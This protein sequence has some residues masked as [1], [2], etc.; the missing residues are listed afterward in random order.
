[1]DMAKWLRDIGFERYEP[2]FAEHAIDADVVAELTEA[3]LEKLQIPLGDRKRLLKAIRGTFAEQGEAKHLE[4]AAVRQPQVAERR[5]LTVMICDLVGSTALSARLDP[6]DTAAVFDAFH[7]T[8]ARIVKAYDGFLSDFRGDGILAYFGHPRAHEDDAERTV[9]AALDIIDGTSRLV[10]RA[11]EPLSVRIGIASG[12]VVVGDLSGGGAL[13]DNA[14]IGDPPN[15][16]SRL[17]ALAEPGKIVIAGATRRLL[18]NAFRLRDLGR[19]DLKGFAEPVAAWSVE[20]IVALESRFKAAHPTGLT[21]LIDREEE[22]TF[23]RQ[24]QRLAWGGEGQIV[25]ISGEEGVGKSR[26]IASLAE[27][28]ADTEHIQLLYQCS[29][30]HSNSV[31]YPFIAQLERAAGFKDDD[32]SEQRLEKLETVLGRG[33][34]RVDEEAPLFATMLSLPFAGRY[35]PLALSPPQQRRR[36]LSAIL[37]YIEGLARKGPLLFAFEDAHW[38]DATS[39]ELLNLLI[40]RVRQLPVLGLFTFRSEFE[41]PWAGFQQVSMMSLGRLERQHIEP[42]VTQVTAGRKLPV[43]VMKQIVAKTDGNPLFIEELTK[44]VLE[45]EI[46]IDDGDGYRASGPLPP[47]AIPATLQDSLMARLDRLGPAKEIA[48]VGSAIGREFSYSLVSALV[49]R[50]DSALRHALEQLEDSE[51]VICRGDPPDAM[52]TFKHALVQEVAYESL[53]KSRRNLLHAEIARALENRFHSLVDSQP[54]ILARHFTEA[55]LVD[56]AIDYWLK[57]G[58]LALSRSANAEAVKHLREGLKLTESQPQSA[59]RFRHEL[60]LYLALGPATAATEGDAA[61]ETLRIFSRARELLGNAGSPTEQMTV[62]WGAYLAQSE[63]A[64]HRRALDVA[65]Q[66]LTLAADNEHPGLSALANRFMG[67]TLSNMGLFAEARTQLERTLAICASHK[68][69]IAAYR[70]FGTDDEVMALSFLAMTLLLLGH[71]DQSD[72]AI[73]QALARA[74]GLRLAFTTSWALS[75]A[76][77]LGVLGWRP[78]NA[79][80]HAEEAIAHSVEHGLV[81]HERRARFFHGA[82]LAQNDDPHRGVALMG[83]SLSVTKSTARNRRTLF[84]GQLAS[85]H[86]RL[87]RPEVAFDML[88]EAIQTAETTHERF[89]EAELCRL[90]GTVLIALGKRDEADARLR[91]ALTIARQQNARWWELRA[92]TSLARQWQAEGKPAEAYLLLE[93]VYRGFTEGFDTAELQSA[94]ALLDSL[95]GPWGPT[96][97]SEQ[98]H[99]IAS[100]KNQD[101]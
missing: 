39:L 94:K 101:R 41:P 93:P 74:R 32:T 7:S 99:L 54:E 98:A 97:E 1:M 45:T 40:D 75:H 86:A 69:T 31:L 29:L 51:L 3:D 28:V 62:L 25:L 23:L 21:A 4:S 65:R 14:L 95:S 13:W 17:Q 11:A 60:D 44:A 55:G 89:F 68:E 56:R 52:Y 64:E 2:L 91:Q 15:L 53:L 100:S 67:Q 79:A 48:Q 63:R 84:L 85:A 96:G 49:G 43:E 10:T 42:I 26:I 78:R 33:L 30:Y 81:G 70:R 38:A 5:H 58:N 24:R 88:E 61:P 83:D 19:H 47:L 8:C 9:R 66:F 46:L 20:G 34:S 50:G 57:A 12:L 87:G 22:R 92:A 37:D 71:P 36:T 73:Q 6:E 80:T 59:R 35:P 77:L 72:A 76:A 27:G 18:P 90:Q 82:L 16:A